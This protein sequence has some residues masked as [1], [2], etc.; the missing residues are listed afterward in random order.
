MTKLQESVVVITGA[1]SGIGR[2]TALE[3]ARKGAHVVAAAR[4]DEPLRDLAREADPLR[5]DVEVV[6]V[7]VT[8]EEQVRSLSRRAVDRFGRVDIWVNNAAVT[9]F[10][11]VDDV[12]LQNFRRVWDIN[13][14]GY[15]HG[16]RAVLPHMRE[17]RSGV[18]V[19]VSSVVGRVGQ[20]YA[21]A[22]TTTKHAIRALSIGLRQ[23][24]LLDGIEGVSV[25]TVMPASIDTPL[26]QHGANYTG[27]L[28][29]PMSPVYTPEKVA[30]AIV[31]CARSPKAE[32]FV[33]GA[34]RMMNLQSHV[35]PRLSERM[36]AHQVDKDHFDKT[37]YSEPKTG[38]LYAPVPYGAEMSGGW[39][40]RNG[41]GLRR[42]ATLGL[43][44][45]GAL[46]VV[47][48]GLSGRT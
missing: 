21:T 37:V 26:F 42:V 47:R 46:L 16:I 27:W 6:P 10:G 33:G 4:R 43:G 41:G 13:V 32:V 22:Y 3:F 11:R 7:D 28:P 5:G 14:M 40:G 25:C 39:N 38:N 29:K 36:L 30:K 8:D 20:P 35:S 23:E 12:P 45:L 17:Q 44:A 48:R 2:A 31:A 1:S 34:A 9:A 18:I 19:N 24:L 15:L